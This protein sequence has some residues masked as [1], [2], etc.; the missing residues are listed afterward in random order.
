LAN[1]PPE[2]EEISTDEEEGVT[3]A[4]EWLKYN[5]PIPHERVLAELGLSA[6]DFERMGQTALPEGS[7][8]PSH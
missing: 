5:N 8:E 1:A 3:Q 4:R 7:S 6:A 2:D